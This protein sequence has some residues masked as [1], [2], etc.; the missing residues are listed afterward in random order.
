MKI[1]CVFLF[2]DD[3]AKQRPF[4]RENSVNSF[5]KWHPDIDVIVLNDELLKGYDMTTHFYSGGLARFSFIKDL[6]TKGY[7]KVIS[8]GGDTITCSRLDEFLDDDKTPMLCTLDFKNKIPPDMYPQEM[9]PLIMPNHGVFEWPTINSDVCCVNDPRIITQMEKLCH[10]KK[11]HEQ[12]AMNYI[13]PNG[14]KIVDFPYEFSTVVYNNRA[15]GWL[16]TGCVIDGKLHF[17]FDGPKVGEFNPMQVWKPIGNKL[18]NH[19]GKHVKVFHFCCQNTTDDPTRTWFNEET[20]SFFVEHCACNW[21][22]RWN[23]VQT[24]FMPPKGH[25]LANLLIMLSDFFYNV[26]DGLVHESIKENE[27]SR[28]LTINFKTTDRTDLPKYKPRIII[29]DF[30]AKYVHPLVRKLVSPSQELI[31]VLEKHK[32]VVKGVQL[33][34]HARRGGASPDSVKIVDPPTDCFATDSAIK[35]MVKAADQFNGNVFLAS[36]SP[37]T[38]KLF[39]AKTLDINISVLHGNEEKVGIF[40]DFFLLSQCPQIIV[41]GGSFPNHPGMSTFGYMAAIYGNKPFIVIKN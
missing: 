15:K 12:G 11:L 25:G 19:V 21:N 10:E 14:I 36:D 34:I 4:Y 26:P 38:K 23:N 20:I 13:Y 3:Y 27:F 40:L 32:D 7:T 33:G 17:G 39:N 16:G 37:E 2:T 24:M 29:N 30:T 1:C 22:L 5:K 18:F 41:T 28:W 31:E 35:E 6:F 9:Q 8:L